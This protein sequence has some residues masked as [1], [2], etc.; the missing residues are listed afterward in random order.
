MITTTRER[1]AGSTK[2]SNSEILL[3][4]DSIDGN[5]L[6]EKGVHIVAGRDTLKVA[7]TK[8]IFLITGETCRG[9]FNIVHTLSEA[10]RKRPD[11][12]LSVEARLILV[13]VLLFV[14]IEKLIL[15]VE[16]LAPGTEELIARVIIR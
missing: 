14:F 16:E 5:A 11:L 9:S 13:Q 12:E 7:L 6:H 8:A 1:F 4:A 2:H 15:Q 10:K 3:R